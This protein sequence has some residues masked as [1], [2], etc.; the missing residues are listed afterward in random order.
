MKA[1]PLVKFM[2]MAFFLSPTVSHAFGNDTLFLDFDYAIQGVKWGVNQDNKDPALK[3]KTEG[4]TMMRLGG[5]LGFDQEEIL[6]YHIERPFQNTPQQ[7]EML[8]SNGSTSEGLGKSVG[9][10]NLAPL[11]TLLLPEDSLATVLIR[12]A[13]SIRIK[14]TKELYFNEATALTDVIFLPEDAV[15]DYDQRTVTGSRN[16]PA[17]QKLSSKSRVTEKEITIPLGSTNFLYYVNNELVKVS[18]HDLRLGYFQREWNRP[19]DTTALTVTAKPIVYEA[20]Y[21][22]EG[23]VFSF[24]PADPGSAGI[25]FDI[26]WKRG[27]NNSIK[28]PIDWEKIAQNK[29]DYNFSAVRLGLWYNYYFEPTQKGW[30][31]TLGGNW[32]KTTMDIDVYLDPE[33]T[34][35][36]TMVH[37]D[38]SFTR[39]YLRTAYRF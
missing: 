22:A 5:S 8:V 11:V 36:K 24:E 28:S 15:F 35:T 21:C 9:I 18:R 39:Y 27:L 10:F 20:A 37:D 31:V 7:R 19:T 23:F 17:G 34:N 38:D 29:I 4:L 26:S 33:Q 14:E 6:S 1:A 3:Y 12:K 2:V 16:I 32:E 13:L 30:S 25:N